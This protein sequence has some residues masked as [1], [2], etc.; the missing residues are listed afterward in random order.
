MATSGRKSWIAAFLL[1]AMIW[2]MWF[3][4]VPSQ[5]LALA[6]AQVRDLSLLITVVPALPWT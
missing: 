3:I 4:S 1:L 5:A 2:T 6:Q